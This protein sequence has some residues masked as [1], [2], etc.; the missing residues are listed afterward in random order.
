MAGQ[1]MVAVA[2]PIGEAASWVRESWLKDFIIVDLIMV[3]I[4][5]LFF[6]ISV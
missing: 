1:P 2:M 5:I 3:I 6:L 4:K